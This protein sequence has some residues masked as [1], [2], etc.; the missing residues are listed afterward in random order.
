MQTDETDEIAGP[1]AAPA[2]SAIDPAPQ[3]PAAEPAPGPAVAT[4]PLSEA[5]AQLHEASRATHD[6]LLRVAADFDNFK[7]RSRRDQ[8]EA[9]RRAEEKVVLAF[10]PVLDNL[11]RALA[12]TE[13]VPGNLFD[14]VAMVQKQFL[15]TLERFDIRPFE[16]IG[17]TFDPERHEAIQQAS[18][19][20]PLGT[21]CQVMQRGY[22]RGERLV[23]PAMV[24]VSLGPA[25][26]AAPA[27]ETNPPAP[28]PPPEAAPAGDAAEKP[29]TGEP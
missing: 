20:R 5:V 6:R 16:S 15:A 23:R 28:A 4:S 24:V 7:K 21:I 3:P 29:K 19:D 26:E 8:Q 25:G 11:E 27:P 10:L 13:G 2:A 12:H 18:S 17:Q 14:G 1:P 9:T 22:C